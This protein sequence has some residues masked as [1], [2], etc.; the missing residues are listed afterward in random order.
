MFRFITFSGLTWGSECIFTHGSGE[1]PDTEELNGGRI[2]RIPFPFPNTSDIL[3][4]LQ[5]GSKGPRGGV[6]YQG[7]EERACTVTRLVAEIS[8][9]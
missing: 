2:P 9:S 7:Q 3:D 4:F 8:R 1:N 5:G 6:L